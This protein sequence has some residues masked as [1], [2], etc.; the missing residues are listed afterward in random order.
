MEMAS[1]LFKK[2][3]IKVE[4]SFFGLKTKVT[5]LTTNSPVNGLSLEYDCTNGKKVMDFMNTAPSG[6]D[7][8]IEKEG[9]P[10][11]SDN[12][13][14]LLTLCYSKDH[15]F[16]AFQLF[17]YSNFEY[18]VVGEIKFYE[19]SDAEKELSPFIK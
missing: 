16:A 4:K 5:Y 19:G 11:T 8:L 12:G 2:S 17:Q 10:Q 14:M 3:C 7:Q 6:I 1:V 18:H 15:Q 9:K 13:N